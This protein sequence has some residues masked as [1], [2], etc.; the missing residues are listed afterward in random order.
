M[1]GPISFMPLQRPQGMPVQ[2]APAPLPAQRAVA[3]RTAER[4]KLERSA[5]DFESLLLGTMLRSMRASTDELA[6]DA[7]APTGTGL[8]RD[9]MDENL[10]VALAHKGGIGLGHD[11]GQQL[12]AQ[13][14]RHT[15]A[16]DSAPAVH[17]GGTR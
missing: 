8:M 13:S 11:L 15:A 10:S 7:D 3:P 17:D 12:E 1:P 4:L 16:K 9:V 6:E 5:Q 2:A 14:Q